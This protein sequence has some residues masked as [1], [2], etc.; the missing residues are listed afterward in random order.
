M[1]KIRFRA[2]LGVIILSMVSVVGPCTMVTFATMSEEMLDM[3]AQNNIMFY[4]P[5]GSN[6]CVEAGSENTQ[7][8]DPSEVFVEMGENGSSIMGTLM[9][10]GYTAQSAAAILGNLWAESKF[11]P[12]VFEGGAIAAEDFRAWDG[13]KTYTGGFGI[14]Q[15]DFYTRVEALQNYADSHGYPVTSL[16]AQV[17]FMIEELP[18]YGLG[19]SGMNAMSMED[20]VYTMWRSYENPNTA[21]YDARLAN[22]YSFL[23]IEPSEMPE[24]VPNYDYDGTSGGGSE[25]VNCVPE[26]AGGSG[27]P[28]TIDGVISY[29]Q[30]DPEWGDFNY[31]REGIHG[32]DENS[33]CDSGCGPSSFASILATLG[34]KGVTPADTSDIA[35]KAG[36]HVHGN[37]SSWDLT[38]FLANNYGLQ[39]EPL[40]NAGVETIN[41][42]LKAGQMI[43]A[44]GAGGL[45]FTGGG[46]YVAIVGITDSGEWIV[47]DPYQ[48]GEHQAVGTYDPNQVLSGM[49]NSWAV[50]R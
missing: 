25:Y 37:G 23:G 6:P 1:N 28:V 49:L 45:P 19:P 43:H 27:S 34:M 12:R 5:Y 16:Q 13:G 36:M 44:V 50:G 31:G 42:K 26:G 21:D 7:A 48:Y 39:Y 30:C 3:F 29:S 38:R 2:I 15:W 22:A 9:A 41:S 32:S 40:G 14:V 47:A 4:D 11:N 8:I 35:G 33:I 18:S 46:H 24:L 10:N 17:G 20:A